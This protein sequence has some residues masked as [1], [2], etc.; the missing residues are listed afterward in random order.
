[1]CRRAGLQDDGIREPLLAFGQNP[2]WAYTVRVSFETTLPMETTKADCPDVRRRAAESLLNHL[3]EPDVVAWT[4]GAAQG[5]TRQGGAGV[6]LQFGDEERKWCIA[7]G[8]FTSSFAAECHAL[9]EMLGGLLSLL[10]DDVVPLAREVRVCTDSLAALKALEAG[11]TAQRHPICQT[12]WRRLEACAAPDRHFTLVWVPGHAGLRGNELA[13][14]QARR[15]GL[16]EQQETPIGLLPAVAAIKAAAKA[17]ARERYLEAMDP[18]HHHRLATGG[19]TLQRV[20]RFSA[21]ELVALRR[22]RVNGHTSCR[23]TLAR[24]DKVDEATGVPITPDCPH[25]PGETQDAAHVLCRCS[26][27]TDERTLHLGPNPS[28]NV[29]QDNCEA[30]VEYLRAIGLL[31][32]VMAP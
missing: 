27:W 12:I 23:A 2:P 8:E 1:M 25:C 20:G 29:L 15:G 5:G 19:K 11:P 6:V 9:A 14:D 30:V 26:R 3:P 10:Q 7:A 24:W 28:L 13:D 32:P 17:A 18:A 21:A 16:M 31:A 22:F 4:D